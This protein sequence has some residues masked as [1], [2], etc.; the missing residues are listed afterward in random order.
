MPVEQHWEKPPWHSSYEENNY[1]DLFYSL[2]RIYRPKTVVELGTKAGYSAFH[3]AR[4]LK[5][6]GQGMLHCYD[7][8][9]KYSFHSVPQTV[10]EEN[11]KDF[12]NLINFNLR[13][14]VG[15]DK[16]YKSIDVL[17]VDVSNEGGILE[18]IIPQW[19]DKVRR[20]II[21]E[22]GSDERDIV[23]WMIK[24]KKVPI[25]KW[26]TDFTNRRSDIEYFT[27]EPFPSVTII[28]KIKL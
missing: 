22:G 14:A 16:L 27:I 25:A 9:E 3:I 8:W 28:H 26:L 23:G 15:V 13:D 24:Y 21:I 6:N 2:I 18:Q 4:G 20:F 10:A 1:G 5:A 11:T 12:K 7:L 19:V 17:H